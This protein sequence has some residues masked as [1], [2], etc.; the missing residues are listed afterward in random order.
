MTVEERARL[1][2]EVYW[3]TIDQL[4]R[5]TTEPSAESLRG[6]IAVVMILDGAE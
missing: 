5:A 6:W 3:S 4:D 2:R 1:A